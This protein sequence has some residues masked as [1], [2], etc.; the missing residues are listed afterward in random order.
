MKCSTWHL[1]HNKCSWNE[2][3]S[4]QNSYHHH[5]SL[6]NT[7]TL[8]T[9]SFNHNVYVPFTASVSSFTTHNKV[10]RSGLYLTSTKKH[11]PYKITILIHPGTNSPSSPLQEAGKD[12]AGSLG[13]QFFPPATV[14][15]WEAFILTSQQW[16]TCLHPTLMEVCGS[17]SFFLT[18]GKG[19]LVNHSQLRTQR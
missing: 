10:T 9:S 16:Y 7:D 4:H 19:W 1:A 12:P 11:P 2:Q 3:L 8:T 5:L 17:D 13:L 14:G 18:W 6:L 15:E